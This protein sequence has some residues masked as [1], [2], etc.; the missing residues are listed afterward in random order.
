[1][2]FVIMEKI[3]V[4]NIQRFSVHDGPG[5]RTT[6]F[7][8]GCLL[9]CPWCA[10]PENLNANIQSFVENGRADTYGN[11]Y[12]IDELFKIIIR[13]KSFFIGRLDS[14][15]WNISEEKDIIN[16]PGGITFSGGEPLL[17]INKIEKLIKR[18][19]DEKIHTCVETS[20]F[21][22]ID[23]VRVAVELIDFFYIDF[24]LMDPKSVKE[25]INGDFSL[26]MNNLKYIAENTIKPVV[27]RVPI[28]GG[29]TD[30]SDNIR[31][32]VDVINDVRSCGMNILKVELL[33]E[34]H[35]GISKYKSLGYPIPEYYGVSDERMR[36]IRDSMLEINVPIEICSV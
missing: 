26:F 15:K 8:K 29:K 10:N 31:H 17:F 19:I 2:L 33:K 3:V 24:K 32:I 34:H 1:M 28:I 13:D 12:S 5:I 30:G 14:S 4:T 11:V 9:R 36:E 35:L 6:V 27:I 18:L 16:L 20:L 23:S 21:V 22:P 25:I 7:L